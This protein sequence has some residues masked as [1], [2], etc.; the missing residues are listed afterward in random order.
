[1]S[2]YLYDYDSFGNPLYANLDEENLKFI[3]E[4]TG[5]EYFRSVDEETLEEIYA[6]LNQEIVREAEETDVSRTFYYL[7]V[8][9]LLAG[10]LMAFGKRQVIP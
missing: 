2:R 5:G 7:G 3:A 10:M 9:A 8:I 4:E 1:M 6:G